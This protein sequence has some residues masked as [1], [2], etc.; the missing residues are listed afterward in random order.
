MVE[1][2]SRSMKSLLATRP[3]YHKRDETLRGHVFCSFL[4]L[5]LRKELQDRLERKGRS[6]E[7]ADVLRDLDRLQEVELSIGGK[8]YVMRTETK[9]TVGKV[10]P[11][12]GVAIPPTCHGR[13]VG[14]AKT[15]SLHLCQTRKFPPNSN[16][17][18]GGAEDGFGLTYPNVALPRCETIGHV[19]DPI[20]RLD[21]DYRHARR[22]AIEIFA[23]IFR[24]GNGIGRRF[25][26]VCGPTTR[27]KGFHCR[28]PS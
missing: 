7:R 4:A 25:S 11:A 28:S 22:R 19:A 15:C 1:D 8:S 6:L 18:S 24:A 16:L 26:L 9:G 5:V 12:C 23:S 2:I 14:F 21:F 17:Q 3:I 27:I 20:A 10:F 13:R